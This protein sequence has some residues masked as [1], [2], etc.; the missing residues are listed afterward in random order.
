MKKSSS[1][2]NKLLLQVLSVTILAFGLTMFFVSKYSYETAQDDA[3]QYVVEVASKYALEVQ[4]DITNSLTVT[5]MLASKFE[6][7][8]QNEVRLHKKETIE[9]FKSILD[10]NPQILGIWFKIKIK[11]NFLIL[12]QKIVIL[13]AMIKLD[14]LILL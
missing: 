6:Q 5:R 2:G 7:A 13:K 12:F 3:E 10:H 4:Q 8:L 1:F 9:F 14:N 11:V